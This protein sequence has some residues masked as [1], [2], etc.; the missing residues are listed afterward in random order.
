MV[1]PLRNQVWATETVKHRFLLADPRCC[2]RTWSF[3]LDECQGSTQVGS[4][5]LVSTPAPSAV[6]RSKTLLCAVLYQGD[7]I[8]TILPGDTDSTGLFPLLCCG[9]VIDKETPRRS[10]SPTGSTLATLT[11]QGSTMESNTFCVKRIRMENKIGGKRGNQ[12]SIVRGNWP[13]K[14]D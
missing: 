12:R 11:S 2:K 9:G 1:S 10:A 14:V 4:P 13:V 8:L 6:N 7:G 5:E 3:Y